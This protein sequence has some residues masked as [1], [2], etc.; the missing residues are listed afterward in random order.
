MNRIS[1]GSTGQIPLPKMVLN[2]DDTKKVPS[3]I[4]PTTRNI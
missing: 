2:K 4:N 3:I 1:F